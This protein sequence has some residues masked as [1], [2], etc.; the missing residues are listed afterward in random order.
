MFMAI[1]A[2][3]AYKVIT[4]GGEWTDAVTLMWDEETAG[5]FAAIMSFWFGNRAV[6]KMTGRTQ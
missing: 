1:K 6:T 2:V 3:I 4:A 5:L